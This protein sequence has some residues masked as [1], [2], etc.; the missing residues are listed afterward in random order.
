M[1]GGKKILTNSSVLILS[2]LINLVL[3]FITTSLIARSLGPELYGKYTFGLSFIMLCS[4]LANFGIESLFIREAARNKENIN[5]MFMDVFHLKCILAFL[6]SVITVIVVNF[7]DYPD[8]T[9]H[10]VYILSIG[11]FFQIISSSVL[12]V[13]KSME[14][15]VVVA[16]FSI[17]FRVITAILIIICIYLDLGIMGPVATFSFGNILVFIGSYIVFYRDFRLL[18]FRLNPYGWA[19]IISKGGPFFISALLTM[20]YS[21]ANLLLLSKIQGELEIG[22]YMAA[23]TLVESLYFIPEAVTT[24]LFPAFSRIYNSSTTYLEKVYSKMI[25]YI[26][27]ISVAVCG[28]SLLV[29][30]EILLLIFGE[31][32]LE[33]VAALYVLIFVWMFSFLSNMMSYLLF[34]IK[35]EK[36]QMKVMGFACITNILLNLLLIPKYS[37]IGSA[38]A[39][40][41]TEG[42]VVLIMGGILWKNNL[43]YIPDW[44][45]LRLIGVL[46]IMVLTVQALSGY[47]VLIEISAGAFSYI[48]SLFILKAFDADDIATM[49]LLIKRN[50]M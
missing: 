32:F 1:I 46:I 15:M 48:V 49:K 47:N 17:I 43:K 5:K 25:K 20:I 45:I 38:F 18:N 4:V 29:G 30:H 2:S 12:C 24:S 50:T 40:V 34:S 35:Q 26:I 39:L 23:W 42:L 8:S 14:K 31:S 33:A 10:V 6:T 37:F 3:S 9:V 22:L 41:I 16:F 19:K 36:A 27:M 44:T 11:L 28:G 21:K 7:L 13:Y